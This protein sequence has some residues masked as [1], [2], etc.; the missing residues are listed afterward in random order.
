MADFGPPFFL[1]QRSSEDM[2]FA[3]RAGKALEGEASI[4]EGLF[5]GPFAAIGDQH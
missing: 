2:S 3:G 4:A 5:Y 1:L